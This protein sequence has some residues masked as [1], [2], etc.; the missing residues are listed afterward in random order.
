MEILYLIF[1]SFG[2]RDALHTAY[3]GEY[4]HFRYLDFLV[5]REKNPRNYPIEN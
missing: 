4:L 1:G 3:T 5:V 2:D